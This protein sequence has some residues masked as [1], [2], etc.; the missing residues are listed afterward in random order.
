MSY[1]INDIIKI[2][3]NAGVGE[4]KITKE[5]SSKDVN[6]GRAGIFENNASNLRVELYILRHED[7]DKLILISVPGQVEDLY[8][9]IFDDYG[10][11]MDFLCK[12]HKTEERV[13]ELIE[14]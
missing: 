9:M 13:F 4:L 10:H 7:Y 14:N 1:K 5:L 6:R 8:C 2:N 11:R 3:N 12:V